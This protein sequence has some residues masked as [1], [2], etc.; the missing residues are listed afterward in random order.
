MIGGGPFTLTQKGGT[1][2]IKGVTPASRSFAMGGGSDSF[3]VDVSLDNCAWTASPSAGW[4]HVSPGGS[5]GDSAVA[6]AVDENPGPSSRTG[7]INVTLG[8]SGKK[9]AFTVKQ[10]GK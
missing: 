5:S 3:S 7:K 9:A 8:Q 6:Y 1:C 2:T 4:L 10:A